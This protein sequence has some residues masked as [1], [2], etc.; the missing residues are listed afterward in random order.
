MP[1]APDDYDINV[2]INCPFDDLYRPLF[3]ATIFV[4]YDAGYRPRSALESSDGGE[5][6][7]DKIMRIIADHRGV[8]AE[9]S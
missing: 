6:R 5:V 2:F 8:P 9:H 4:L 7:V 3:Q 1:F